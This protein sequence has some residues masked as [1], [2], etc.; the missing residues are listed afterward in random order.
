MDLKSFS[1]LTPTHYAVLGTLLTAFALQINGL[2]SWHEA[3]HPSFVSGMISA[4][5]AVLVGI[6]SAKPLPSNSI[7]PRP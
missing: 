5:A 4:M 7:T 1:N 6:G 2:T 3:I